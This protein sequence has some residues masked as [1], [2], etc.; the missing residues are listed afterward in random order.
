MAQL[1]PV[2]V[3]RLCR[4]RERQRLAG[5]VVERLRTAPKSKL[6]DALPRA[7]WDEWYIFE[8]PADLGT[9]CL[10]ENIFEVQEDP[11]HLLVF[12]NHCFTPHQPE[13]EDISSMFWK[14]LERVSPESYVADNDYLTFVSMNKTL[15]ANVHD[16][17]KALAQ[18]C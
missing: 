4:L 14:Q 7:G 12:V 8:N 13:M 18:R 6:Q 10:G 5:G 9:S 11:E 15:F 3:V 1:R 17:V 2:T 16:A